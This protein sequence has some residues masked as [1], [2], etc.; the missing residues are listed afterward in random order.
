MYIH[1]H[2]YIYTYMYIY[3][4]TYIYSACFPASTDLN[5]C[6]K[7][8]IS[9]ATKTC[10]TTHPKK[11]RVWRSAFMA[12]ITQKDVDNRWLTPTHWSG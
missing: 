12:K 5:P 2:I 4:Y 9:L 8:T 1:I 6:Q 11:N 10:E 3:I 7:Q